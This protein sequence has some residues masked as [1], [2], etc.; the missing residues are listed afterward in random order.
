MLYRRNTSTR[1]RRSHYIRRS[2][3]SPGSNFPLPTL[4]GTTA[5]LIPNRKCVEMMTLCYAPKSNARVPEQ[6]SSKYH[7]SNR[8]AWIP[9]SNH[10]KSLKTFKTATAIRSKHP[11]GA[12]SAPL[13]PHDKPVN[14]PKERQEWHRKQWQEWE[15][16]TNLS[17]PFLDE[18]SENNR[19]RVP[20][21]AR[22]PNGQANRF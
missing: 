15:A 6:T 5:I 19:Y 12:M 4:H 20:G 2:L 13:T 7:K 17:L 16:G 3:L 18:E 10:S 8:S 1:A 21:K 11:H 22:V 9:R 14:S